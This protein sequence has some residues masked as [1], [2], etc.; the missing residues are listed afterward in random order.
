L[1][2]TLA[3]PKESEEWVQ[4]TISLRHF[5]NRQKKIRQKIETGFAK[6]GFE[7]GTEVAE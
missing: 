2:L 6:P 3:R 1:E 7:F 4:G 5:F